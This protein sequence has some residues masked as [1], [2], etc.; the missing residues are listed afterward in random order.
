MEFPIGN[1]RGK[2]GEN[3]VLGAPKEVKGCPRE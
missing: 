2:W 1:F 3:R